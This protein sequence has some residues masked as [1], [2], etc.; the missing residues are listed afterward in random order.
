LSLPCLALREVIFLSLR[1]EEV[2]ME[3]AAHIA[4]VGAKVLITNVHHVCLD[5]L[6]QPKAHPEQLLV[7]GCILKDSVS[8]I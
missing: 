8:V 1:E 4:R 2:L 6:I 3:A 5:M 7:L